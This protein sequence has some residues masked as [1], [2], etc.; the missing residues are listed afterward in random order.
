MSVQ[1]AGIHAI[2]SMDP[3]FANQRLV[4]EIIIIA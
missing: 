4:Q 2:E 1:I 3:V